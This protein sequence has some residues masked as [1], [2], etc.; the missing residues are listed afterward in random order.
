MVGAEAAWERARGKDVIVAVIDTGVA[1][2]DSPRG[3]RARDFGQTRFARGYDFVH[4]DE[5]PYDDQGHGTHVAGTVAESTNNHEGVAG[6]AF[7]AT[8][9]PLKVLSSQGSGTTTDVAD[10]IRYAADKGARVKA[11]DMASA[12]T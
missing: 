9:L 12:R 6:L 4:D 11:H 7:E 2:K 1:A 3:K 5:D 8:I 10:A